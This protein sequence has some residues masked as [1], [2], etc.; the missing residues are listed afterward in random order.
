MP[1]PLY[2]SR[3]GA[4]D[5][6]PASMSA[7]ARINDFIH[8]SE[9]LS[10]SY[11]VSTGDG[12]VVINT[13]MG[14]EAPV[15]K[16]NFDAVDSSPTRFILLTQGHVDH[17]GGV[18][19][20][21]EEGC[22]VVAQSGNPRYQAEDGL[23]RRVRS[24][25]SFFAFAK[26]IADQ[27]RHDAVPGPIPSQSIPTPTI[28]F[29]DHFEFDLGGRRFE[30]ISTPGGETSEAMVV[31][32]PDQRIL[33]T[34]NVFGALWGHIPNLVTIR[35]D[36]YRDALVVVDTIERVLELDPELIL[37]GHHAPIEGRDLIRDE[38][39]R[40]KS[41]LLYVH[42]RTVEYMNAGK[43]VWTA[44]REIELPS[45]LEVGQ[46][47]GKVDWDVRAIWENYLGWFHQASTTELYSTPARAVHADLVELAG[48]AKTIVARAR[49]KLE[50][51][52]AVEAIHLI[53][54]SLSVEPN[55]RPSLE[56]A[57]EAHEQL[58]RA[59]KN[60]WLSSWLRRQIEI[61][62]GRLTSEG[63]EDP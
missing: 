46:G 16:R 12:R 44:M 57:I 45:E 50:C 35:G 21:W 62:R 13:G 56:L 59:S 3:P 42:D 53:E 5:L 54:I 63:D 51:G 7:A 25:R 22:E 18:D 19:L 38:L 36:R 11:L 34:G 40:L 28:N 29:D 41:A 55:H 8:V 15:H 60:F 37:Y 20:F 43:D 24:Q 26:A 31:W 17:V 48:G 27:A 14:F 6:R 61:L 58:D 30:L 52:A 2:Q 1:D 47:Y 32:L 10:N 9:G 39:G 4:F 49:E 33:F 23:L